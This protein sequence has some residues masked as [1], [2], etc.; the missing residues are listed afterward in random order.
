MSTRVL[1]LLVLAA[2]SLA[3]PARAGVPIAGFEETIFQGGLSSP[4]AIAFLPDARMLITEKAGAL[5]LSDG[6][7]ATTLVTIPTC[8]SP[9]DSETGLLGVAID[10]SFTSNHFIYLYRT[11]NS[12]GCGSSTGRFNQ[13]VRVTMGPGDTVSLGSLVVLLT[14]ARTDN[15]NHDGAASASVPTASSTSAS[16]TPESAIRPRRA[17]RPTRMLRI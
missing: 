17:I 14:G 9:F 12:N 6:S 7:S 3:P 13:V 11:D 8:G 4:T 1:A 2:V 10:P 15:G 16:A 5:K